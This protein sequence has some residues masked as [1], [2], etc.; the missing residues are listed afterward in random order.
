MR[1]MTR[2]MLLAAL[3]LPAACGT[4]TPSASST[5][6]QETTLAFDAAADA[7]ATASDAEPAAEELPVTVETAAAEEAPVAAE[8]APAGEAPAA[9]NTK[10]YSAP[11][12]MVID[13]NKTYVATIETTKGTLKAELFAK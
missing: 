8:T 10:Q 6:P 7:P 11:P 3:L 4:P 12:E 9:G 1:I 13:Q 5:V 2:W